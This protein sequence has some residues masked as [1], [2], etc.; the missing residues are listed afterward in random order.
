M[1]LRLMNLRA[2]KRRPNRN[3]LW[4]AFWNEHDGQYG[5]IENERMV[6]HYRRIM[7]SRIHFYEK[8]LPYDRRGEIYV[9]Y[10]EP[11]DLRLFLDIANLEPYDNFQTSNN[12]SVAE[13]A[14]Y[15]ALDTTDLEA[16]EYVLTVT[17]TDRHADTSVT[18]SVNF[19]VVER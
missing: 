9:R 2:R 14:E 1:S 13:E 17:L 6:E 11:D 5:T 19:M 18:K 15:T 12:P 3:A 7:Y 10:G 8:Q 4:L 16:G